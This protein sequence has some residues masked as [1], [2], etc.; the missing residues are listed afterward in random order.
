M[1]VAVVAEGSSENVV[2][3]RSEHCWSLIDGVCESLL[4]TLPVLSKELVEPT[5]KLTS[6]N[7]FVWCPLVGLFGLANGLEPFV[8]GLPPKDEFAI[9]EDSDGLI[10]V[11]EGSVDRSSTVAAYLSTRPWRAYCNPSPSVWSSSVTLSS[12]LMWSSLELGASRGKLE[13]SSSAGI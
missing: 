9:P 7:E 11:G 12:D 10:V 3:C 8:A 2:S 1:L 13:S 6:T 5:T 4:V